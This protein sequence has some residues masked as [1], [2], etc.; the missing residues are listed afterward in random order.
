M[1]KSEVIG[2]IKKDKKR[3]TKAKLL[4][5]DY[6]ED[7]TDFVDVNTVCEFIGSF[8]DVTT[9]Y[10]NLEYLEQIGYLELYMRYDKRWYRKKEDYEAHEH[11]ITCKICGKKEL[12]HFCPFTNLENK[13]IK[14]FDVKEHIFEL[15]GICNSCRNNKN[16][17]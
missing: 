6:F 7:N 3:L 4:I 17:K 1:D 14:D 2:L 8:A 15:I 9:I 11:Y 12:L 13:D 16:E 5:I 10:R